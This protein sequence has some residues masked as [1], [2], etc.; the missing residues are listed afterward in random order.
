[1]KKTQNKK[2]N[3]FSKENEKLIKN[4]Y[5]DPDFNNVVEGDVI[6]CANC[7]VRRNID[8][9]PFINSENIEIAEN[10]YNKFTPAFSKAFNAKYRALPFDT[11]A[12]NSTNLMLTAR[13]P[14]IAALL[15]EP[16]IDSYYAYLAD[17][18]SDDYFM[19]SDVYRKKPSRYTLLCYDDHITHIATSNN[20]VDAI[21]TALND[22][23][24]FAK[25]EGVNFAAHDHFGY[26]TTRPEYCGTGITVAT[27]LALPALAIR[28]GL[29]AVLNGVQRLEYDITPVIEPLNK[30]DA[31]FAEKQRSAL[32][33]NAA[34]GALYYISVNVPQ[35]NYEEFIKQYTETVCAVAKAELEERRKLALAN[36][37]LNNPDKIQSLVA[38]YANNGENFP[39]H[40]IEGYILGLIK[41][42][43]LAHCTLFDVLS[44]L[45]I[46]K[47]LLQ[48]DEAASDSVDNI[49]SYALYM[50]HENCCRWN[51]KDFDI[52]LIYH[53]V[54]NH[55]I[56]DQIG[57]CENIK[58]LNLLSE[59][60][61]EMVCIAD[62]LEKA[63]KKS[64]RSTKAKKPATT[65][66]KKTK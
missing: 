40:I 28:G 35:E 23:D 19:C 64:K 5:N 22:L 6:L 30:I 38:I 26:L 24:K 15:G 46:F 34:P 52:N 45:T 39:L 59:R 9:K 32:F 13:S 43:L 61:E 42:G 25:T 62:E 17:E 58:D 10:F 4:M 21:N 60:V 51:D 65:K 18:R 11:K 2:Q 63:S 29:K 49:S 48:C 47:Y 55:F 12:F 7:V 16:A 8:D 31:I 20:V 57:R 53:H 1:M 66:A 36:F 14:F 37:N 41:Q 54:G 33:N 44:V 50:N 56:V 3:Y 27:L